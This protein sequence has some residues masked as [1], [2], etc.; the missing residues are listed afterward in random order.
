MK[1]SVLLLGSGGREHA[2][3]RSLNQS[4]HLS[5][6]FVMPGNPGTASLGTNISIAADDVAAIVDWIRLNHVDL[7][8]CGPEAPL[9]NGLMDEIRA[10][11]PQQKIG[12]IGPGK[13]GALLESSKSY[14]KSFM[15]RHQ[16]PTAAYSAFQSH[17]MNDVLQ[18]IHR[19]QPPI[20]LKAD[21]LAAGKGVVICP[22]HGSAIQEAGEMLSGK[23]G[24]ASS[25]LVIE[26]FLHG[27]EFSV[28][29]LTDGKD[30]VLLPEAKDY[31]RIGE[32]DNGPNTGGMGAVSPVHFVNDELMSK[33]LSRIVVP[34][35]NGLRKENIPYCGIVFFGLINVKGDP[36]VIEYN[37]RLGDPETEV[38]LPR[39]ETDLLTLFLA[40]T[41]GTLSGTIAKISKQFATTIVLASQG[42]PAAFEKGKSVHLPSMLDRSQILFHSGTIQDNHGI[43]TAGGRVFAATGLGVSQADALLK[44]NE[45]AASVHFEGKYF[46]RDIGF[47]L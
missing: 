33:V 20:V 25:T 24:S 14:A 42:Y 3:A 21:G 13:A 35:I 37:V 18:F 23:F 30:F 8:I 22:D 47:D 32:G 31:K 29:A 2:L 26:E 10:A 46:R 9:A 28:F 40:A 41:E 45:L 15:A 44:A 38:I 1:K 6:L 36:F 4:P 16:I 27:I 43:K 12:L 17:Q 19:L 7:V 5:S 11:F 34:T 39:L